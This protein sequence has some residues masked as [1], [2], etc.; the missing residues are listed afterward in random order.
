MKYR[1]L[2]RTGLKISVVGLGFWQAGSV[3][4]GWREGFREGVERVKS[5]I[6]NA[7]SN[8]INFYDTAEIYGWGRS[9]RLL[10]R[11]V[12]ELGIRD[13]VVIVSKIGG[14]R[15]RFNDMLKAVKGISERLGFKPDIVLH[16]WP[17]PVYVNI[18]RV[19][20]NLERL[21][22]EGYA[23]YYGLSN[24]ADQL[25]VKTLSCVRKYEP[26]IDQLHYNL[27]YRVIENHTKR[28]LEENNIVLVAWSPIAKGALAGL[29]KPVTIAQAS[30]SVFK[31][32]AHDDELQSIL[33]KLSSKYG[34]SKAAIALS[35]LIY[36][37]AVPIPGTRKPRRVL[38]YV[39]AAR[40]ELDKEDLD[41]LDQASLKYVTKWGRKYSSLR[42]MRLIP[43]IIQYFSI[44]ITGG[45]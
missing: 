19:I 4:W 25:L 21:V 14:F 36:R 1:V 30:D 29:R 31:S 44:R 43:G 23:S 7:Y 3:Y 8:G 18:C 34:V 6:E 27:G 22:E 40:I 32:V 20:H 13:E 28:V 37:N 11:A 35:W 33:D 17:P 10:G 38:E 45:I 39:D 9:E 41:L 24:Y 26:V 16:H 42:Y 5:I 12:R 15:Y 2:G